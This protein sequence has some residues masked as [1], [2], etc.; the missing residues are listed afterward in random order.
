MYIIRK[1][2]I[3]I[4]ITEPHHNSLRIVEPPVNN[5]FRVR[6]A[7]VTEQYRL[8]GFKDGEVKFG[9]QSYSQLSKRCGNGWD[10]NL[11]SMIFN[12]IFKTAKL[13]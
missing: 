4:T 3:C 11:V 12:K 6:K 10:I 8:M 7:S 1:L 13:I 5:E 9:N 2:G